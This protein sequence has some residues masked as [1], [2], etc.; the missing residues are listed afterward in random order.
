MFVD[1][2]SIHTADNGVAGEVEIDC[3]TSSGFFADQSNFSDFVRG[4]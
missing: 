4:A 1:E 3:T 2:M